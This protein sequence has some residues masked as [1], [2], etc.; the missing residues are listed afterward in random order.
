MDLPALLL[1]RREGLDAQ[2]EHADRQ[3]ER[4]VAAIELAVARG[5][6]R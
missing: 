1:I 5:L 4:A 3:L 2:R 6:F